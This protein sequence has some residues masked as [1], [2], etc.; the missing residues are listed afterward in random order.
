M[1]RSLN[2]EEE[3]LRGLNKIKTIDSIVLKLKMNKI[4]TKNVKIG[5]FVTNTVCSMDGIILNL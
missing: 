1:V 4:G 5:V 3:L 2:T